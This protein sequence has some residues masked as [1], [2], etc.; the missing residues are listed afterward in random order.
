MSMSIAAPAAGN[1]RR[2]HWLV[3]THYRMRAASFAMTFAFIG[4][5][6]AGRDYSLVAWG[7]LALQ[8]IVYPHLVYWRARRA[9]DPLQAEMN[10]LVLDSLLFGMWAAALQFPLWVTFALFIS[11]ALNNTVNRGAKGTVLALLAFFGGALIAV[12]LFGFRLSPHTDWPI[13]LLGVTGLSLYL[14]AIGNIAY[15]SN[16]KLRRTREQ[17]RQGE[18]ALHAANDALV[19]QLDEIHALQAQLKEQANRDP[20]TGL[21]NRRYLDSTLERELARCKREGHP[22]SLLLFDIDYFK[23][24]NDTYGH[25]AGDEVLRS[26]AA[27]LGQQARV[28]DVACRFGGE[29]FLMLL[30]SMPL[31]TAQER[32]EQWRTAFA[33]TIIAF[34]EFRMQT[35]LSIGIATYPGHGTSPEE[36]IRCADH[37][38]YR[39]KA[40]GRNRV[41]AFGAQVPVVSV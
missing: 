3:Q 18:Q 29:E 33:A 6:M 35:T 26:L 36:L 39:A 10:N 4:G 37:A 23:Q 19:Q 27:M 14:L 38:L 24:V 7:L 16:Q 15:A 41:V 31:A 12:F 32:A 8:F 17:L 25:Q 40:E 30:P 22:L 1:T 21:Y 5:H 28:G 34:G 13:T 11:S 2:P 9:P 20:L